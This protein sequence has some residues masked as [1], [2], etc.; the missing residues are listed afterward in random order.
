[1]VPGEFSRRAVAGDSGSPGGIRLIVAEGQSF[2]AARI[3]E[4]VSNAIVAGLNTTIKERCWTAEAEMGPKVQTALKDIRGA[5]GRLRE[6]AC[7]LA[8]A[9]DQ[10]ADGAGRLKGGINQVHAGTLKLSRGVGELKAGVVQAVD[11]IGKLRDGIVQLN[12]AAPGAS[13]LV[14]LNRGVEQLTGGIVTLASG[15]TALA[16][17]SRSA[18]TGAKR[19]SEGA[20]DLHKNVA[21]SWLSPTTP[22]MSK[23]SSELS[24][25]LS[26]TISEHDNP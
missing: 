20:G 24:A 21:A 17:G 23:G 9:G 7:T 15:C 10:L 13:Q 1:M 22:T 3:T 19:L 14:P 2:F 25:G 16:E 4:S 8:G 5:V 26:G 6:G 11:G 12:L 18:A